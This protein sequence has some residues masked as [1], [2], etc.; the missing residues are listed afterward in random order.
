MDEEFAG[1][2]RVTSTLED[3]ELGQSRIRGTVDTVS[4]DFEFQ[5]DSDLLLL[6]GGA[7]SHEQ[8]FYPD[9]REQ[10][11]S[12]SLHFE[13]FGDVPREVVVKE[14]LLRLG[15]GFDAASLRLAAERVVVGV[16]GGLV[17]RDGQHPHP[18]A[19]VGHDL[20][21]LADGG[22]GRGRRGPSA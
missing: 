4:E 14:D 1:K 15:V 19:E 17:A 12:N 22:R 2:L 20:H 8:P 11:F 18:R 16:R 5:A 7:F 13:M 21:V 9:E 10:L 3:P 6:S